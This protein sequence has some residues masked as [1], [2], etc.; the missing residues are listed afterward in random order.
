M[1]L[2]GEMIMKVQELIKNI[3]NK[4]FNMEK[5]LKIKN[6]ISIM[7]KKRFVMDVIASCTDENDGF[8]FVDRF[9]M[10]IYFNMKMLGLYTNLEVEE[11]FDDMIEQY[12]ILCENGLFDNIIAVFKDDYAAM[13][14]VL[15]GMLDELLVQNSIEAQVVRIANKLSAMIDAIS[16]N[17]GDIDLNAILPDG[18]SIMELMSKIKA[19]K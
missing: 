17:L 5:S 18:A 7:E 10:N 11:N 12:D 15:D 16:D 1:E 2:K 6:Y 9:K 19:L 14:K 4:T 8:V 13:C 3:N